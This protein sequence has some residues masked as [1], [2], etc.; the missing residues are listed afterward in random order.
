M[1]LK[2]TDGHYLISKMKLKSLKCID[3]P[4]VV[5]SVGGVKKRCISCAKKR[6]QTLQHKHYDKY[7]DKDISEKV[8]IAF[9]YWAV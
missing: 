8:K 4:R 9:D 3:C 6:Q 1:Q 7:R 2:K 5:S